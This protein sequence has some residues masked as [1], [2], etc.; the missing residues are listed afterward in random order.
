MFRFKQLVKTFLK[1]KFHLYSLNPAN[2][3]DRPA[4][5][6]AIL[7]RSGLAV[8]SVVDVGAARGEWT[9]TCLAVFPEA[10]CLMIDPLSENV[11]P[12]RSV[13]D[14]W[15]AVR[16]WTGAVGDQAGELKI[17][18]H[19]DQSSLLASE[20]GGDL[21]TVPVRTLDSFLDD[22]T[23]PGVD[24]SKIDVQGAELSVLRGADRV[25]A[26]C[27]AIQIEVGFRKVYQGAAT[28]HEV[29]A[30]LG[31]RGFRIYD[32]CDVCKREDRALLQCDLF[33]VKDGRLFLPESW[34]LKSH[35][36]SD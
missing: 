20:W 9:R 14:E 29:I 2:L 13:C 32:I 34:S 23:M 21:R 12:L 35:Q 4:D 22:G 36:V 31:Q 16:Y 5:V 10:S 8:R 28:A 18:A 6:L 19:G 17:F 30:Y 7:K 11:M 27:Q 33:F 15:P 1:N 25:L 3:L 24:F 26:Q